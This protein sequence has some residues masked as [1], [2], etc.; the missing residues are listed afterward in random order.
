MA[1]PFDV[2][3]TSAVTILKPNGS[4]S[5][6]V[7]ASVEDGRIEIHDLTVAVAQGDYAIRA[8]PNGQHEYYEVQWV[9]YKDGI[10]GHIP[11]WIVLHC[12]RRKEPMPV[13][14]S[15]SHVTIFRARGT[16]DEKSWEAQMGGDRARKALFYIDDRVKTGDEI[17]CELFDEPKI[18]SKV[19]PS[20][21]M[22]GVSHWEAEMMPRSE[23]QRRYGS[24]SHNITVTGQGARVNVGSTDQSVQHFHNVQ[25]D[26]AIVHLLEEIKTAIQQNFGTTAESKD[27]ALDVDQLKIELQRSRPD[28][29]LVW[30]LVERLNSLAGLAEKVS[31]LTPLLQHLGL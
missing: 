18:I 12:I 16:P 11:Q 9:E 1:N 13:F 29:S 15:H 3:L 6:S 30:T 20:M 7:K 25:D 10:A 22:S 8:L 27:A 14:G 19:D 26:A 31:K 5:A 2:F 28:K 4:Q 24:P 21:T 23:W 17:H